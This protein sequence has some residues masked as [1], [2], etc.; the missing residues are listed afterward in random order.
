MRILQVGKYYAPV[1]GGIEN[2]VHSLSRALA[3]EHDVTAL[4]FNT[5]RRTVEETMEGVRVIRVGSLGK[6]RSVEI[7]PSFPRWIGRVPADLVHLHVPNPVGAL[8]VRL[9][10]HMGGL[11]VTYH[12][13]IVRQKALKAIYAPLLG[14]VLDRADRII[15][16]SLRY[17]ETSTTLAA[18]R[19][20]CVVIPLGLDLADYRI[21]PGIEARAAELRSLHGERIVLFVGRMVYYKGVDVLLHA[22]RDLDAKII[23]AGDGP[24]REPMQKLAGELGLAGKVLFMGDI[25]HQEKLALY[26][27]SKVAVLPATHR[28]EAFGLVQVEAHACG[29][30][31]VSTDL[32]SGVPF[33]NEDGV[34][35]LIVPPSD[36]GALA[37]ALRRLLGDDG[38]REKL[39]EG[40][41]ARAVREFSLE[42]VVR[43]TVAL[44]EEVTRMRGTAG[45][46]PGR[47]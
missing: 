46:G 12:S 41:R 10:R 38:L 26:R 8:G 18:W 22:A 42:R 5:G 1:R 4:V 17:L 19:D 44:Y 6:V 23:V 9:S 25:P 14:A 43:D 32:D 35:G 45:R 30:P 33:V 47:D 31:V 40:A 27:A 20:K 37:K 3:R 16:S 24:T 39:G 15:V 21:T 11:V 28:S 2:V 36:P 29:R 34:S 13:D 7:A